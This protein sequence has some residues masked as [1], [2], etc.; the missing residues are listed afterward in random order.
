MLI[1]HHKKFIFT[2]TAKT[3]GTSVESFFEEYCMPIGAWTESHQREEHVSEAG[4]VGYRGPNAHGKK[5]YNHMPAV[6]IRARIGD[7]VWSDYFK[8]TVV[9]NPFTKLVSAFF[10][11]FEPA[12]KDRRSKID[13]FRRWVSGGSI[14]IDRDKYFIDGSLC[15]DDFIRFEDLEGGIRRICRKLGISVG[16]KSLPRF[17]Q[18]S[19]GLGLKLEDLYDTAT[20]EIVEKAYAWEIENFEYSLHS[21][22]SA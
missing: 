9:R 20:R 11:F 7:E 14:L 12:C 10:F 19:V 4:V 18:R 15:V 8:F 2:K 17:K 6:E 3:A 21:S 13:G 16:S 22:T 1:S 5:W